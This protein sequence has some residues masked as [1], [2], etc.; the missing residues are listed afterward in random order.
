MLEINTIQQE[1]TENKL[2]RLIKH[3]DVKSVLQQKYTCL[4]MYKH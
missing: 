2:T 3:K 4:K 1:V